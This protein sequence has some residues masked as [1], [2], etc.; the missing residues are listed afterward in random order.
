MADG[1]SP[2]NPATNQSAELDWSAAQRILADAS[3]GADDAEIFVDHVVTNP[4][5]AAAKRG[6]DARAAF[7]NR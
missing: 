1:Q 4:Q 3:L 5:Q 2:Q 7:T 6:E